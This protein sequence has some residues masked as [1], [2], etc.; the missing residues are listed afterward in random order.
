[1]TT[2][3]R[4]VRALRALAAIAI[5]GLD[6]LLKSILREGLLTDDRL[7]NDPELKLKNRLDRHVT[8]KSVVNLN[9]PQSDTVA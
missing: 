5:A 1:M 2:F 4:S 7:K 8:Q 6:R 3:A 9:K